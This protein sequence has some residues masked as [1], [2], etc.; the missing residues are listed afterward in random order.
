MITLL[1]RKYTKCL[2]LTVIEEQ[3]IW[4]VVYKKLLC[5]YRYGFSHVFDNP[6]I[7]NP[8]WTSSKFKS[9]DIDNFKHI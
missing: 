4:S 2:L 6:T 9:E 3:L 8:K 1:Y 5:D 7:Y